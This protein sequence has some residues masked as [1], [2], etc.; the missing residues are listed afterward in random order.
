MSTLFAVQDGTWR[1]LLDSIQ[2]ARDWQANEIC[3]VNFNEDDLALYGARLHEEWAVYQ[4]PMRLQD[5]VNDVLATEPPF[6]AQFT[7]DSH[8]E[9]MLGAGADAVVFNEVLREFRP[10]PLSE[11]I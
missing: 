9:E 7:L 8:V 2:T 1:R 10:V 11:A 4:V 5:T 6:G 3:L